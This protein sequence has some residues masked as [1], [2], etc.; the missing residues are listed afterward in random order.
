MS[1]AA[2]VEAAEKLTI[3]TAAE[4][5]TACHKLLELALKNGI[6]PP[7][8][9]NW[10]EQLVGSVITVTTQDD[11]SQHAVLAPSGAP[12]WFVCPGSVVLTQ[13]VANA[14]PRSTDV[15]ITEEMVE[16]VDVAVRWVLEYL[17]AN[18]GCVLYTEERARAGV[19]FG[20]PD[21]MWGTADVVIVNLVKLELVVFDAK[22]GFNE[23]Q[24]NRNPQLLLYAIGLACDFGWAFKTYLNVILQPRSE[25][26]VKREVLT[27][28]ELNA[29]AFRI[30]PKVKAAL[31]QWESPMLELVAT[32]EGCK[33]CSAAGVC[34]ELQKRALQLAKREFAEPELLPREDL[35]LLLKEADR[36][37]AGLNAARVHALRLLQLG[38]EVPGFKLV[39]G[40]KRRIWRE[41]APEVPLVLEDL[42][43]SHDAI[44]QQKLITPA[45]AEKKVGKHFEDLLQ[46]Y[47]EKPLGE[48]TLAPE[49]DPRLPLPPEFEPC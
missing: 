35:V 1:E 29:E 46:P 5:G 30:H 38:Q 11:S 2:V 47:I 33:W 27:Q 36:I 13:K 19:P 20:C 17:A 32:D 49:S 8:L 39:R 25:I 18:P 24:V 23:V 31:A 45:Q 43:L 22:F 41:D 15:V 28:G 42:G 7:L 16:W 34:P 37:E 6:R 12:R 3:E 26:P 4:V 48:P 40:I 44:W 21:E 14:A 9:F 10:P